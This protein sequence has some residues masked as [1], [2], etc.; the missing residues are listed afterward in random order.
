[1]N[2]K[3]VIVGGEGNGGVI[4]SCIEDNKRRFGNHEWEV[5]GFI[6]DYE[7]EVAGYPVIGGLGTIPDLLLNTDY[8]FFWAIHLVGRNVLTEQ[9]FRKAN[10]PKDRLATI[11][12]QSAF[13]A[14]NAIIEPGVFIM[15]NCYVG[16]MAQIGV[17]SM[18]MANS[19]IGH[20]IKMGPLCNCSVGSIMTGYSEL[21]LC[22][23]LAVGST[24]L[25]YVKVGN[26]ATAGAASLVTKDIPDYEIHVGIPAKFLKRVRED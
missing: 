1:M 14:A 9:L 16:P 19:M 21:G 8:Y 4:V 6:N 17:C 20:N 11:I 22:A 24:L 7:K 13:V 26:F 2:K 5:V 10:I 18:I 15:A 23:D 12:H 25:A 3:V